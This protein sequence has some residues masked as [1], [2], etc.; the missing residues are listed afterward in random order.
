MI[1][2]RKKLTR[3]VREVFITPGSE[4]EWFGYYNYDT[5]NHNQTKLLCNRSKQE[6]VAPEKGMT[7]ELGYYD[8]FKSEWHHIGETDSWN[9]QQ[10]CMMQ[11]LPPYD[12]DIIFNLSRDNKLISRIYNINTNSYKDIDYPIYGIMP[13]GK[14]SISIDLERSYWCRAYH[15][16]SVINESLNVAIPQSDGIFFIDL[17]NNTRKR[18][19]NIT[20]V[21]KLDSDVDFGNLKHWFEHVMISPTGK[22]FCFLHRFSPIENAFT[23]QTRLCI[24]NIDGSNLQIIPGWRDYSFSH[25]G[26]C[27]D[28]KFA[29]YAVKVPN[30][31]KTLT[32]ARKKASG[33][34]ASILSLPALKSRIL[35]SVKSMLPRRIKDLIKGD[36]NCY[37]LY[38]CGSS[39]KFEFKEEWHHPFFK[40]DGHPSFT[41]DGNYMITD[42][43]ADSRGYRKLLVYNIY[44]KKCLLLASFYEP[45]VGNPARCDLHPKL[46]KNNKFVVV[47]STYSGKH[48]ILVFELEWD[49]IKKE[50]D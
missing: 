45:F 37:R 46:C 15:Y 42:T 12:G 8:I 17:D 2:D 14:R 27:G 11:W 49:L 28:D 35:S 40:I 25:F 5:L 39:G 48:K 29:I 22:R 4:S 47:D 24:A 6:A 32:S 1:M 13:D 7:L 30:L 19:I 18:I 34:A 3:F 41:N 36:V 33:S 10:G 9:W 38:Q 16:E 43:Y 23:Y 50:I 26:W 20:D 21:L 31:Q 44:S